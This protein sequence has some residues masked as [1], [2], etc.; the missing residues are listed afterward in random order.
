MNHHNSSSPCNY[1]GVNSNLDVSNSPT[2]MFGAQSGKQSDNNDNAR[3]QLEAS[4]LM[5]SANDPKVQESLLYH[6]LD[7]STSQGGLDA[8]LRAS[9]VR[10]TRKMI[11]SNSVHENMTQAIVPPT[12]KPQVNPQLRSQHLA[13]NAIQNRCS[14]SVDG[15]PNPLIGSRGLSNHRSS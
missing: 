13:K 9:N 6:H 8:D 1:D 10:L 5:W 4:G 3:F 15:H 12:A 2:A 11:A 14:S 7:D